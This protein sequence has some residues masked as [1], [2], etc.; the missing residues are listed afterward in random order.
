[1]PDDLQSEAWM[2]FDAIGEVLGK[3]AGAGNKH[4]ARIMACAPHCLEG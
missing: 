3:A 4:V 2:A 1:M